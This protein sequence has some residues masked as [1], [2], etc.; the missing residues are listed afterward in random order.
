MNDQTDVKGAYRIAAE[1]CA[2]P[3]APMAMPD[4]VIERRVAFRLPRWLSVRWPAWS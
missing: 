1:Q 3:V 2:L 4:Q